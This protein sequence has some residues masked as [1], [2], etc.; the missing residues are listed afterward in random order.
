M[1]YIWANR[2]ATN[3]N[4]AIHWCRHYAKM[5]ISSFNICLNVN[6]DIDDSQ[7]FTQ[8]FQS[9]L[10][11]VNI[12]VDRCQYSPIRMNDYMNNIICNNSGLFVPADYDEFIEYDLQ[13]ESIKLQESPYI[14]MKGVLIDRVCLIDKKIHLKT[15]NVV[16]AIEYQFPTERDLHIIINKRINK[17]VLIKQSQKLTPGHHEH[18]G[19]KQIPNYP[20]TDFKVMH[21]CW[22]N[23]TLFDK[24]NRS[25]CSN[26]KYKKMS[27]II[28]NNKRF[29][30]ILYDNS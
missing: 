12:S 18:M 19:Y 27:D 11:N 21:Y 16:D 22:T 6:S 13:K 14:S 4:V 23:T 3:E 20:G 9:N 28:K 1:A 30:K 24:T 8:L 17:I 15:P 2:L 26:N 5:P 25:N 10:R 7:F 29:A